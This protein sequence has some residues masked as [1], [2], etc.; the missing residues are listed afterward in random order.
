MQ[1]YVAAKN[2]RAAWWIA[3]F[4]SREAEPCGHCDVCARK[5]KNAGN[6]A[7][8]W[9]LKIKQHLESTDHDIN[10]L[11]DL[12]P[13]DDAVKQLRLLMDEGIIA[14][15]SEGKLVWVNP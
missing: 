3:Y 10:S 13:D 11:L 15:N 9:R 14:A 4:T 8:D 6:T 5:K 2:C 12:L 1:Q 7:G